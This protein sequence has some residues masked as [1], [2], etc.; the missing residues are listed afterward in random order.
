[1]PLS[2]VAYVAMS[3]EV[4]HPILV[5]LSATYRV[6]D[7][8]QYVNDTEWYYSLCLPHVEFV[9]WIISSSWHESICEWYRVISFTLSAT[10]RVRD[11]TLHISS[12]WYESYHSICERYRVILFTLSATCRVRDW[13]EP[14]EV[15]FASDLIHSISFTHQSQT[16]YHSLNSHE[17]DIIHSSVTNSI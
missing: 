2:L 3:S 15:H 11:F 4:I 16:W 6:R 8:D 10:S 14:K 7:M 5:T 9:M 13:W 12:S 1:M 17:L